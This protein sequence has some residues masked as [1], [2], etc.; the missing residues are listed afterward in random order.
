MSVHTRVFSP[1]QVEAAVFYANLS[2]SLLNLNETE[3]VEVKSAA[4]TIVEGLGY[5]LDYPSNVR[6]SMS[7]CIHWC[8]Y[9]YIQSLM[10]QSCVVF[11]REAPLMRSSSLLPIHRAYC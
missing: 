7:H 6:G 5:I 9:F 4:S 1:L 2:L 11:C 3:E 8:F 10:T